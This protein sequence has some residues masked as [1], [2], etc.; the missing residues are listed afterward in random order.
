MAAGNLLFV[1]DLALEIDQLLQTCHAYLGRKLIGHIDRLRPFARIEVVHE[2][3]EDAHLFHERECLVEILLPLTGKSDHHIGR[4]GDARDRIP[5]IGDEPEI[6][7]T[8]VFAV[9]QR[10]N[11]RRTAL[12]RDMQMLCDSALRCDHLDQLI[13][14]VLRMG[15]LEPDPSDRGDFRGDIRKKIGETHRPA[16][17]LVTVGVHVLTQ[18]C[19]LP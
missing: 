17:P 19:D 2:G 1:S 5:K 7:L 6:A 8:V 3:L 14:E 18:Q 15:T 13:G 12:Q 4:E 11:A 16:V 9:H 10:K